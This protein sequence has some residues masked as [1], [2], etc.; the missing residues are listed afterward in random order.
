MKPPTFDYIAPK[1][2]DDAV[3]LLEQHE[4][5]AKLLSGGQS[6]MPLLNMRLARPELLIDLAHVPDLDYVRE[7][8]AGLAVGA[9]TRQRTVELSSLVRERH[10]LL[11]DALTYVAH[12][13]NRNQGTVGGSVAHADP[14]AE[15]PA[16]A[17]LLDAEMTVVGPTGVRKIAAA[18]FFLTYLTTSLEMTEVLTEVH[19]PLLGARTGYSIQ[20]LTRR[21]GDFALAGVMSTVTLDGSGKIDRARMAIFGVADRALRCPDAEAMVVGEVPSESLFEAAA[22]RAVEVMD[23]PLSDVHATAEYRRSLAGVLTRRALAEAADKAATRS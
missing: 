8:R 18:D 14:A 9:M 15:L 20:E 10:P 17:T 3:S 16:L 1:S 4:F 21:H 12:P 7:E 13:Q 11:Y 19:W 2:I 6:L 5:D 22:E 23:E